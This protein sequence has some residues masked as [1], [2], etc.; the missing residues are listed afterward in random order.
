MCVC[1]CVYV[2][3]VGVGGVGEGAVSAEPLLDSEY[4][5]FRYTEFDKC[6]ILYL[7]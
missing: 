7:P 1:D 2:C 6:L 3:E 5:F 4:H